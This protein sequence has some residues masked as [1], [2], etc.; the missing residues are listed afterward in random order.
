M[1]QKYRL[2]NNALITLLSRVLGFLRD[3]VFARMFGATPVLDAF[4][5][6]FRIP[7]L[8][9]RFFAEGVFMQSMLPCVMQNQKNHNL[10]QD[11][12]SWLVLVLLVIS[13]PF[14]VF[15]QFAIWLFA[16]GIHNEETY[17]M[18][19]S[20]VP[21]TFPYL[22]FIS[23]CGYYT[24][25]LNISGHLWVTSLLPVLLNVCLI[26]GAICF[27]STLG[28]AKM[29]F[30]AGL[31]QLLLCLVV[32]AYVKGLSGIR[33]PR[34]SSSLGQFVNMASKGFLAQVVQYASSC[35]DLLILSFLPGG[36]ISVIYFAE[37]LVQM[38]LGIFAVTLTNIYAPLFSESI[39][40][41]DELRLQQL[42]HAAIKKTLMI[43]LPALGGLWLLSDEVMQLL[44]GQQSDYVLAS[45]IALRGYAFAL[46]AMMINKI[47][48]TYLLAK[49]QADKI[50]KSASIGFGLSVLTC[51]VFFKP[52]GYQA[53]IL[54]AIVS[55][56]MQ[57]ILLYRSLNME[58]AVFW[59][60]I[61]IAAI[62][63]VLM[64]C[65]LK[66]LSGVLAFGILGLIIKVISSMIVYDIVLHR[67]GASL[68]EVL[69]LQF[70][71]ELK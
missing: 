52:L 28:I 2:I 7:N 9:R 4:F 26:I 58:S 48:T 1:A 43:G 37:R 45:A 33:V 62:A 18:V 36:Y 59:Q 57:C 20:Q 3:I 66:V 34:Y 5:M 10:L 71:R 51:L 21:W 17:Q 30:I 61:G 70:N 47:L 64:S 49:K 55:A 69:L 8:F 63:S 27:Q 22:F 13:L 11:L 12:L 44:Y 46:P 19:L 14:V 68:K 32:T 50:L 67:F 38:P 39:V 29:V 41:D 16:P 65:W 15:P 54:A 23:L 60:C 40:A 53:V 35:F 24:V 56:W 6:A 25:I 31:I 42:L